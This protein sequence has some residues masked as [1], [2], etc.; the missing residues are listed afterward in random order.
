MWS[1]KYF[2]VSVESLRSPVVLYV[3]MG[4]LHRGTSVHPLSYNNV[5]TRCAHVRTHK[6]LFGYGLE[7]IARAQMHIAANFFARI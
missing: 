2:V 6:L 7:L 3:R 4:P 1:T 5:Y